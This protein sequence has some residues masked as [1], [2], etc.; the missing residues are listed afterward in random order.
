MAAFQDLSTEHLSR[1]VWTIRNQKL[2]DRHHSGIKRASFRDILYR[3]RPIVQG[4]WGVRPGWFAPSW[5][6]GAA[7][8]QIMGADFQAGANLAASVPF[9]R[10]HAGKPRIDRSVPFDTFGG[11]PRG[12]WIAR[13]SEESLRPRHPSGGRPVASPWIPRIDSCL[14]R[15]PRQSAVPPWRF[16]WTVVRPRYDRAVVNLQAVYYRAPDGSEPVGDFIDR[17]DTKRQ[18]VIDNQVDRL[19]MLTPTS[20]HLPFPHSTQVHGELRELRCHNGAGAV[21]GAVPPVPEPDRPP[22]HVQKDTGAIPEAEIRVAEDR[23][24][25]FKARMDTRKRRPPRAAGHDAP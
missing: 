16:R 6:V 13:R 15:V 25:D 19:N 24:S 1:S 7:P 5:M 2:F 11:W 9:R 8:T 21:S 17:L 22:A 18:V 14:R 3:L 10:W 23:W 12:S 20:P 4:A